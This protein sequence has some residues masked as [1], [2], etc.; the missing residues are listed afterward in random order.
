MISLYK[1]KPS[2]RKDCFSNILLYLQYFML[3]NTAIENK[4]PYILKT[5]EE[6]KKICF[7]CVVNMYSVLEL[8]YVF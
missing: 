5:L 6:I 1:V 3:L 8:K 7:P 2:S 4:L